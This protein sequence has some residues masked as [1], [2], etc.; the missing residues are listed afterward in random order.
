MEDQIVQFS[1]ASRNMTHSGTTASPVQYIP[2][3]NPR[4]RR[5]R[6]VSLC[7]HKESGF[8]LKDS[9]E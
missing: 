4:T 8:V 9:Y 7:S 2:A 6:R 1:I 3:V 5:A